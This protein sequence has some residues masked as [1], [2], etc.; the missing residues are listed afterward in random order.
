[1]LIADE[2]VHSGKDNRDEEHTVQCTLGRTLRGKLHGQAGFYQILQFPAHFV[3]N[4][5]TSARS[6]CCNFL[7][8][9]D[10]S[11]HS[12]DH[13]PKDVNSENSNYCLIL[14]REFLSS[15]RQIPQVGNFCLNF[16]PT[17]QETPEPPRTE[18]REVQEV[19]QSPNPEKFKVT[20]K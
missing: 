6:K 7:S 13:H 3:E 19:P 1:M 16:C 12:G 18:I 15:R 5:R 4:L 8:G 20:R 11:H 9:P 17:S 10:A 2:W 14:V